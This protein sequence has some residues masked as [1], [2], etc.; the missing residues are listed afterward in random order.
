[1]RDFKKGDLSPVIRILKKTRTSVKFNI[2]LYFL[3]SLFFKKKAEVINP[4]LNRKV[5]TT[6]SS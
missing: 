6:F 2:I 4:K 1:M 5:P 3:L